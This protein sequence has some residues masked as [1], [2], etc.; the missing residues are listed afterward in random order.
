MVSRRQK[1]V[2]AEQRASK[3]RRR[4]ATLEVRLAKGG[5]RAWLPKGMVE[6]ALDGSSDHQS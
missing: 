6:E 5:G 4:V 1:H 3:Q 2:A